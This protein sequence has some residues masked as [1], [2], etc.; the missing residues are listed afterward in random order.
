MIVALA[1]SIDRSRRNYPAAKR[2]IDGASAA[3]LGMRLA[4]IEA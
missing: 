2:W 3:M 1:F 4:G